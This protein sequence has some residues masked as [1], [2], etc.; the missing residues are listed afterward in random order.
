MGKRYHTLGQDSHAVEPGEL[1][2]SCEFLLSLIDRGNHKTL[3]AYVSELRAENADTADPLVGSLLESLHH[4]CMAWGCCLDSDDPCGPEDQCRADR[5][6]VLK[7]QLRS[8]CCSIQELLLQSTPSAMEDREPATGRSLTGTI[9]SLLDM[10]SGK[11]PASPK[12]ASKGA[13]LDPA[14]DRS[15]L[16]AGLDG[17]TALAE[18]DQ[19]SVPNRSDL[20]GSMSVYFFG[21]FRVCLDG[22]FVK[23]WRNAKSKLILKYLVAHKQRS[24][25]K[26]YLMELFWPNTDPECARNNL[27][28]AIYN[29]RQTLKQHGRKIR[30]IYYQDGQYCLSPDLQIWTDLDAFINIVDRAKAFAKD[31]DIEKE[32]LALT[33]LDELYVGDVLEE[34]R[35]EDWVL[36]L[37]QQFKEMYWDSLIKRADYYVNKHRYRQSIDM[38]KKI[39][40]IDAC[41]EQVH[42]RLMTCY[43]RLGQHHLAMRQFNKCVEA[44]A[45]ELDIGPDAGTVD[46][47]E[48]VRRR[49]A[50]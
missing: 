1:L 14:A 35:F 8:L 21:A 22:E 30:S 28:V 48:R 12:Q 34:D 47:F 42:A 37:R 38:Y 33:S 40:M 29:I 5:E 31:G 16:D 50:V 43:A 46:L 18:N 23:D 26:E 15:D 3:L 19:D 49:E 17:P 7:G 36:P 27:N 11:K 2:D 24:I 25:A 44:L 39:L 13:H 45:R 10:L 6:H 4:L 41:D 9:V 32:V 20:P